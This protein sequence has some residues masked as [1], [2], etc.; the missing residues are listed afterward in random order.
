LSFS[1]RLAPISRGYF[2]LM[3]LGSSEQPRVI[4]RFNPTVIQLR[5]VT[6][7]RGAVQW[8]VPATALPAE[9]E[10]RYAGD[11]AHWPALANS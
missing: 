7:A 10:A 8:Q 4:L 5:A 1:A 9:L 3:F 11:R 6:D 2:A